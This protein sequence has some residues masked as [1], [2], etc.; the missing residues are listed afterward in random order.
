[1]TTLE[2]NTWNSF[3]DIGANMNIKLH[4]LHSHLDRFPENCGDYSDEQGD[5]FHQDIKV[6]EDR[7]QRCC[8]QRMITDY[9]WS[10]KR[11]TDGHSHSRNSRKRKFTP[12]M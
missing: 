3:A 11:D 8:D 7:Y 2:L 9:Y 4:F 10:I 12:Q 1:M 5:H 6:M